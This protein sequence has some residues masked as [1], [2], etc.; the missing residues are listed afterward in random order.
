MVKKSQR[1]ESKLDALNLAYDLRRDVTRELMGSFAISERKLQAKINAMGG[2]NDL[3]KVITEIELDRDNWFIRQERNEMLRLCRAVPQYIR[4]AQ[5]IYPMYPNEWTKRRELLDLALANCNAIQDELNYVAITLPTDKNRY[6][7]IVL[8]Y[9]K[10]Y[11]YIKNLRQSDNRLIPKMK[12]NYH[13][14]FSV[15]SLFANVNGNGNANCD[16]ASNSNG[17]RTDV[18]DA[19]PDDSTRAT[20]TGENV[21]ANG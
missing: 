16:D 9:N 1:K 21:L 4:M 19:Q 14:A 18:T 15:S 20:A 12:E 3:R 13:R 10:L 6:M 2:S 7:Q 11:N 8:G 17:V 5:S